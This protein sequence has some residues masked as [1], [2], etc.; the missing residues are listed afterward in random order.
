M[1]FGEK[2]K[3]RVLIPCTPHTFAIGLFAEIIY[4]YAIFALILLDFFYI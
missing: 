2:F 1:S 4:P 3:K